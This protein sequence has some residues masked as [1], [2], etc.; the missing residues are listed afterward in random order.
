[1]DEPRES[2]RVGDAAPTRR[3]V[4]RGAALAVA[5]LVTGP[6]VAGK[7]GTADEIA[8]PVPP[9]ATDPIAR[10]FQG[11]LEAEGHVYHNWGRSRET[12]PAVYVEPISVADVQ[13]VVGDAARFP[14]P[15]SV[16]GGM[17]SVTET[18]GN[19]G[20]TIV[21]MRKLDAIQGLER[22]G[23]GRQVVRVEAGCRLKKLHLWLQARDLEIP[24]QAEIGDATVG[25]VA[26]GDTKDSSLG[27][28]GY[29]SAGVVALTYVDETGAVR[30]LDEPTDPGA[31]A[32]FKCS[33]GLSGIIVECLVEV[34]PAILCRSRFGVVRKDSPEALAAT[35]RERQ[36]GCDAFWATVWLDKLAA[37]C[38]ERFQAGPGAVTPAASQPVFDA[39]RIQRRLT[40]QHG[41]SAKALPRPTPPPAEI[42]YSRADGVNEYWRPEATESRLDFQYYEHDLPQLERVIVESHAFTI[43]FQEAHGFL[44]NGWILYFVRRGEQA[45]KPFGLYS[46]GPGVSFSFDPVFSDP[47]D[48][49]WQQF[50][51]DYNA[52]AIHALGGRPSPIQT[53]WLTPGDLTIPKQ[54]ARPRFTTPYYA[55]FL[56]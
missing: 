56:G 50:A 29:F 25:S 21:S 2:E 27:G 40:I 26:A 24:F 10:P 20:G 38:D 4:L 22:D 54:L 28:A 49:L 19:D 7:R 23:A 35:I 32:A 3:G 17:M 52:V 36:A 48:P 13:A 5:G 33:Y 43:R 16:V 30:T 18:I 1:M 45:K 41:L 15:V 55:Q 47:L 39:L 8:A 6:T 9:P 11:L 37:L 42:V 34:R 12:R 51:K 53:Q 31:L 46:G 14:G 44:P